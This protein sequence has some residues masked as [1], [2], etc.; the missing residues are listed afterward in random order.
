MC[1]RKGSLLWFVPLEQLRLTTPEENASTYRF[2]KHVIEHRFCAN[3]GIHP[4]GKGVDPKGQAVAAINIRCLEGLDIAAI[5]VH[6]FD[7]RSM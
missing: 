4:Y 6:H 5:P 2:N 1:Q 3:C 7:G